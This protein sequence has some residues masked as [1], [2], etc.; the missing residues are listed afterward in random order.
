VYCVERPQQICPPG[1]RT[2]T[3][4]PRSEK[5]RPSA[6]AAVAAAAPAAAASSLAASPTRHFPAAS[7]GSAPEPRPISPPPP[8]EPDEEPIENEAAPATRPKSKATKQKVKAQ[9]TRSSSSSTLPESSQQQGVRPVATPQRH[10]GAGGQASQPAN[11]ESVEELKRK[12]QEGQTER[13]Q[14]LKDWLLGLDDGA[15]VLM[16]YFDA[17]CA[18]FDADLTQIAAVKG[19][20]SDGTK[21]LLGE[22]DP[23]FWEAVKVPKMGHRM[24]LARGIS[25]L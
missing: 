17:L 8:E 25:Q 14:K 15:G 19:D 2:E 21:G 3:E 22:V 11:N 18:E 4:L 20:D 23:I 7:A 1:C 10:E 13:E 9:V 5:P 12:R 16:P 6:T 24:L